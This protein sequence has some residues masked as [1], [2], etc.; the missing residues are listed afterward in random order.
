MLQKLKVFSLSLAMLTIIGG[1]ATV[2]HSAQA[3]FEA[4]DNLGQD[5]GVSK[6]RDLK[7]IIVNVIKWLLKIVFVLTVLMLV[8][9]G[10]FYIT[11]AGTDR[12]DMA[13]DILTYAII[14]LVVA[15]LGYAIVWYLGKALTDDAGSGS[16][17]PS[18]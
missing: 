12:A 4:D 18:S 1:L 8:I 14:G 16:G 7:K 11:S 10:I 17:R 15:V 9:S 5:L 3:Q 2:N 6:E 13:R